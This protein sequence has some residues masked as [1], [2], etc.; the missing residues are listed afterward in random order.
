MANGFGVFGIGHQALYAVD[1]FVVVSVSGETRKRRREPINV[2]GRGN[3]QPSSPFRK[4]LKD[5]ALK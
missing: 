3:D 1:N 2:M 4:E 5:K